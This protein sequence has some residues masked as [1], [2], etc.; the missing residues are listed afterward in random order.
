MNANERLLAN[1]TEF[2]LSYLIFHRCRRSNIREKPHQQKRNGK[3]F[4]HS[5]LVKLE[6]SLEIAFIRL[7]LKDIS[8]PS[9]GFALLEHFFLKTP[10]ALFVS[11]FQ[12]GHYIGYNLGQNRQEIYTPPPSTQ[13]KDGK[14][15]R[16]G[17]RAAIS[18]IWGDAGCCSILFCPRLQLLQQRMFLLGCPIDFC[19]VTGVELDP[20]LVSSCASIYKR[21]VMRDKRHKKFQD[22]F[23][24]LAAADF[25]CLDCV[26]LLRQE[27]YN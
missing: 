27:Y 9:P 12:S 13:I 19:F 1:D 26:T 20:A 6:D 24:M 10:Y 3:W 11:C 16:F 25:I 7:T 17:F 8:R 5:L 2:L 22:M 23:P 4:Y 14:M 15:G 18:L 21:C